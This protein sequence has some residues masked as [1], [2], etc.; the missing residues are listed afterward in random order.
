[1]VVTESPATPQAAPPVTPTMIPTPTDPSPQTD[2]VQPAARGV[3]GPGGCLA[4]PCY[5]GR[6]PVPH[7]TRRP[8]FRGS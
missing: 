5:G 2:A 1:M 6:P 3:I 8:P 7:S 4:A